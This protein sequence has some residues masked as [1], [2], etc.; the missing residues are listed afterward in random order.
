MKMKD[1]D[2]TMQGKLKV[3]NAGGAFEETDSSSWKGTKVRKGNKEGV[4]I[5][6]MNGAS[7]ELTVKFGDNAEVVVI[8]MNNIGKDPEYIHDYDWYSDSGNCWYKF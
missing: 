6:D 3:A 2:L 1:T 8:A 4:V 5:R 7:R